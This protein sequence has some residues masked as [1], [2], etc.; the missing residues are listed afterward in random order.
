MN[1]PPHPVPT[2]ITFLRKLATGN[3]QLKHM[4]KLAYFIYINNNCTTNKKIHFPKAFHYLK[5]SVVDPDSS[6][7]PGQ[8]CK[9]KHRA[10]V[11]YHVPWYATPF[12]SFIYLFLVDYSRFRL[13]FVY[14]A[15]L[16]DLFNPF[17]LILS[18]STLGLLFFH[19]VFFISTS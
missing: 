7:K 8:V 17:W 4:L 10:L 14:A 5:I 12:R 13:L 16:V 2:E 3:L 9:R 11:V 6:L 15:S 1:P 19:A 18:S